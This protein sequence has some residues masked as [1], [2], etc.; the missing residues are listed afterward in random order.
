[1][2]GVFLSE[3]MV[4]VKRRGN[5]EHDTSEELKVVQCGLRINYGR[6]RWGQQEDTDNSMYQTCLLLLGQY[7]ENN[8]KPIER[9]QQ[10]RDMIRDMF[11]KDHFG[12]LV[13]KGLKEAWMQGATL[14]TK[15]VA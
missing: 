9:L 10:G 14:E 3:E 13:K 4:C 5:R 8:G 12:S 7:F 6:M 1:M 15:A 2:D 11:C